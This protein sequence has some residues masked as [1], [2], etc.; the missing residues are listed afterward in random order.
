MTG[1]VYLF[2]YVEAAPA[3]EDDAADCLVEF[4]TLAQEAEGCQYA[5]A[6][7]SINRAGEFS[8][9]HPGPPSPYCMKWMAP[10]S[11]PWIS[12]GIS[13]CTRPSQS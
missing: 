2:A 9:A 7:Q 3:G 5:A 13:R 4:S 1:A 8:L 12:A 6:L 11:R 10:W